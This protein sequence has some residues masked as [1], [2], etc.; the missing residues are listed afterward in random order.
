MKK[1]LALVMAL[2]AIS[3]YAGS[4]YV[5]ANV[6]VMTNN[7]DLALNLDAGYMFNKYLGLEGGYTGSNNY[8]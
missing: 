5:D 4:P 8:S 6:G 3:A 1:I 2:S 7:S